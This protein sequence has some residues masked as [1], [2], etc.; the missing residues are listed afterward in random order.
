M[1]LT[2]SGEHFKRRSR[3]QRYSPPGHKE[4]SCHEFCSQKMNLPTMTQTFDRNLDP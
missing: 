3:G 4:A 1:S 2:A